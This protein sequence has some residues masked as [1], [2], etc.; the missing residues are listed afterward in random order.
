MSDMILGHPVEILSLYRARCAQKGPNFDMPVCVLNLRPDPDENIAEAVLMFTQ[1]QCVRIRDTLNDF[2][3]DRTSW[4]YL[5][6][7]RQRQLRSQD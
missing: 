5:P 7:S 2:L 6:K 3:N 1:E 4:L